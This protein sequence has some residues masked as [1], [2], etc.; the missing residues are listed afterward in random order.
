[1]HSAPL[2]GNPLAVDG[3]DIV[4]VEWRAEPGGE[5]PPLYIAPL[6][7][8]RSD[9]EAW[10]VLE[11]TL[12]FILGEERVEVPAGGAA[13]ALRGVPHTFWN[14]APVPAR[15]VLAMTPR[16]KS[17]IDSLHDGSGRSPE[18]VFAAHD[19]E[20]LGWP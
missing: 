19:S 6:H 14:P 15:Y 3:A 17:L 4:L 2:A 9:D 13:I 10:Y 5:D 12:A 20:L 1:M 16:I 18:E 8:H 7:L 11:G